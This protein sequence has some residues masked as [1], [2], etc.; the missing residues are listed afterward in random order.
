LKQHFTEYLK[1][2]AGKGGIDRQIIAEAKLGEIAWRESCPVAGVTGACIDIKRE[3][4]SAA[5]AVAAKAAKSN[6]KLKNKGPL[7]L[8]QCGPATKSKIT[9]HDRRPA[10]VKEA[11]LHFNKA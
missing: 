9:V 4:A 3:R 7:K 10:Q 8:G 11:M 2:W 1:S 6:K 5:A